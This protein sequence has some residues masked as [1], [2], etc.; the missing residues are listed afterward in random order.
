MSVLAKAREDMLGKVPRPLLWG[1]GIALLPAIAFGI[2]HG[3][4]TSV[5][6]GVGAA[7]A[8]TLAGLVAGLAVSLPGKS[9]E[10]L[11]LG[12]GLPLAAMMAWTRLDQPIYVWIVTGIVGLVALVLTFPWWREWREI[13]RLG[14][15][16]LAVPAWVLGTV[17]AVILMNWTVAAQRVVYGGFAILVALLIYQTVRR[18][19]RDITVGMVSGIMLCHATLMVTGAQYLF[20]TGYRYTSQSAWGY[21]Q[22]GRFWGGPWLVYHPNFIGMTAAIV[23]LRIGP[24]PK[25]KPWQRIGAVTAA[26]FLLFHVQSRN[27]FLIAGVGAAAYGLI[28]VWRNGLPRLRFWT[29]VSS[30]ERLRIT[31]KAFAPMLAVC[32][33]F[34]ASGGFELLFKDRYASDSS[35]EGNEDEQVGVAL[36]L[37][38]RGQIWGM[39]GR[40]FVSDTLVEKVF[41]NS[42]NSRGYVLRYPRQEDLA[43]EMPSSNDEQVAKRFQEQP[44]LTADN[45]PIGALRRA[46]VLGVTAFV[47][48]VLLVVWHTTRGGSTPAWVPVVAIG[49]LASG[50]FEDEIA[51]TTAAWMVL[52]AAEAWVFCSALRAREK[53]DDTTTP[54]PTPATVS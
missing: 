47:V 22:S 4:R 33:V 29:W 52:F 43:N 12:L 6:S 15:F 20:A 51:G 5:P 46:G 42:D 2:W 28:H 18:R 9:P 40:D 13:P 37:S 11:L 44:K 39:I 24:D 32:L 35:E 38:G 48:G 54:A 16:W 30:G 8:I 45:G 34:T 25:F 26:L 1:A 19:G 10:G 53:P 49:T 23:A 7:V 17:S 21:A 50:L 36:A 14:G 31:M 3:S 27:S 41:G